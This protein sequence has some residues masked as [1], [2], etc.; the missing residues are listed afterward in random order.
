MRYG[1]MVN[2]HDMVASD[3]DASNSQRN[4]RREGSN[5]KGDGNDRWH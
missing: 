3:L 4:E 5:S 2:R 1:A